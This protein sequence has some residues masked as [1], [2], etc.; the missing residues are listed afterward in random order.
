MI[1][2]RK[3]EVKVVARPDP[4]N[5]TTQLPQI[6]AKAPVNSEGQKPSTLENSPSPLE[7]APVCTSTPWPK[8]GKMSG[9]LFEAR[10]D[11]P[12]PPT[13]N[14]VTATNPKPPTKIEPQEQDQLTPSATAPKTRAME[15]GIKLSH[16]QECRRLG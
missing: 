6:N 13:N 14:T 15:M 9:N 16:L 8:A 7:I 12:I 10:K 3:Y 11:W 4:S 5:A 1:P 2:T